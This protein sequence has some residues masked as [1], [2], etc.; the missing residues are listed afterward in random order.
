MTIQTPDQI[1]DPVFSGSLEAS[2]GQIRAEPTLAQIG[3]PEW[4]FASEVI[5]KSFKPPQGD[6]TYLLLRFAYSLTPPKNH[7]VE[8]ARLSVRLACRGTAT[9]PVVFDLFPREMLEE[10][11][12]D[13]TLKLEPSLK[14]SEVEASIGSVEASIQIPKVEPVVTTAG[15]GGANPVWVYRKHRTHPIIGT[16]MVY[17][18]VGY[19]LAADK[20]TV[21]L[22]LTATVRGRFGLWPLKIPSTAEAQLVRT[23]P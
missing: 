20:M 2:E 21:H 23:I 8:E 7:E 12:R 9:E 6:E 15:I 11:K 1:V 18:I 5:G 4:W 10:S 19:P 17:A 22:G 16:R 14:L 3:R 13:V